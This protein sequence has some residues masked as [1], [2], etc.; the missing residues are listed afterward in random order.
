MAKTCVRRGLVPVGRTVAMFGLLGVPA[1]AQQR[2]WSNAGRRVEDQLGAS[3]VHVPDVD[4][5]GVVDLLVGATGGQLGA[6]GVGKAVLYSGATRALL[7]EFDG[8]APNDQF[9]ALVADLGDVDGDGARDFAISAWNRSVAGA[10]LGAIFVVSGASGATI[11]TIMSASPTGQVGFGMSHLGDVDGDGVRDL[12]YNDWDAVSQSY[13]VLLVSGRTGATIRTHTSANAGYGAAIGRAGD[14]DGDGVDDYMVCDADGSGHVHVYSGA[15]GLQLL[16]LAR[17]ASWVGAAGDVNLDGHAD[18]LVTDVTFTVVHVLSGAT[19]AKLF[20]L[21][22]SDVA[23]WAATSAT[24]DLD[25]DGHPDLVASDV[26]GLHFF[27]GATGGQLS[28]VPIP[29]DDEV[30]ALDATADV[31]GDGVC[32]VLGGNA[33]AFDDDFLQHGDV[34]L[35]SGSDGSSIATIVGVSFESKYGCSLALVDDRDGDGWRDVAVVVPE[36]LDA[37]SRNLVQIVSGRDGHELSRFHTASGI[38]G[39]DREIVSIGDVNGDGIP[40]LAVACPD[41]PYPVPP[42]N[43]VEL[44]SGADDSLITTLVPPSMPFHLAAAAD[45]DGTPLLAVGTWSNGAGAVYVYDL[46]TDA[47]VTSC[48]SDG[49]ALVQCVG[50]LDGD[51]HVDWLALDVVGWGTANVFSGATGATLWSVVGNSASPV[52]TTAAVGDL[53]GDGVDD[54]LVSDV[55]YSSERGKVVALSGASGAEIFE[56]VGAHDFEQLGSTLAPLGDVNGDGVADFVVGAEAFSSDTTSTGA[57]FVYSGAT[58]TQLCRFDPD[59]AD[60]LADSIVANQRWHDEPRLDPDSIPDL[61]VGTP[62]VDSYRGSVDAHQ[63][64]DLMLQVDPPSPNVGDTVTATTRGGPAGNLVGLYALDLSGTPLDY[65]LALGTLNAKGNFVVSDVAPSSLQGETLTVVSYA[66]GFDG[67]LAD[68]ELT[69]ID[70][71]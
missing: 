11:R 63:L 58:A 48:T 32:D 35:W 53:D 9:G 25:G 26:D 42:T 24:G 21:T 57:L 43:A 17:P 37:A 54:V 36:G 40:D 2:L 33:A 50:D 69:A 47:I 4:G 27:S 29:P 46:T 15:T 12:L 59:D 34:Q 6:G 60:G 55:G 28:L 19:G 20:D 7:R 39:D 70:F 10:P 52:S 61:V 31:D 64:D 3:V 8:D 67:K 66:V 23:G 22:T 18:L 5:D 49:G 51:G 14:V 44:H 65:F 41:S 16:K 71:Q 1:L 56:I 13:T 38:R 45:L 68:S 62:V 30:R